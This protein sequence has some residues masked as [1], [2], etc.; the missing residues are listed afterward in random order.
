MSGTSLDGID[1]ALVETDG[2]TI[3]RLGAWLTTPYD[4]GVRE[5]LRDSLGETGPLDD[6]A[7]AVTRA[8]AEAVRALLIGAG[9]EIID[10]YLQSGATF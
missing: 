4:E 9:S 7:R 6:V 10:H 5:R 3:T 8:H 1:A 2:T